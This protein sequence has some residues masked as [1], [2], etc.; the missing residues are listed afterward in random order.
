MMAFHYSDTDY[1]NW[2]GWTFRSGSRGGCGGRGRA[3]FIGRRSPPR[4]LRRSSNPAWYGFSHPGW[5]DFNAVLRKHHTREVA[6]VRGSRNLVAVRVTRPTV[7]TTP[8]T[9]VFP[10]TRFTKPKRKSFPFSAIDVVATTSSRFDPNTINRAPA[11]DAAAISDSIAN[12][13]PLAKSF[14]RARGMSNK[15]EHFFAVASFA[16]RSTRRC[17][18]ILPRRTCLGTRLGPDWS[19]SSATSLR[20]GFAHAG[21]GTCYVWKKGKRG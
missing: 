19:V 1:P 6:G 4:L 16:F 18:S 21:H 2:C 17:Q 13:L 12:T 20:K 15:A 14:T 7:R 8:R 5:R 3:S 11:S 10:V 9:T